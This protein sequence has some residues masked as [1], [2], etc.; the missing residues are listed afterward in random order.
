MPIFNTGTVDTAQEYLELLRPSNDLW[1][2]P[3]S[4]PLDN[5]WIYRGQGDA[6]WPLLPLVWR[7]P[8]PRKK[9]SNIETFIK[10]R[11]KI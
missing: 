10:M 8:K 2:L 6:S 5:G 1:L 4:K 11:K 9:L 3:P 7:K